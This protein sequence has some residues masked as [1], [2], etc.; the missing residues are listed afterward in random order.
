MD[1]SY[2]HFLERKLFVKHRAEIGLSRIMSMF[3]RKE[4]QPLS[5]TPPYQVR[6]LTVEE[7]YSIV[8]LLCLI[9]GTGIIRR[10][11]G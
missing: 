5:S 2:F 7:S 8:S 1:R 11:L 6:V 4:V 3:G 9:L 10:S